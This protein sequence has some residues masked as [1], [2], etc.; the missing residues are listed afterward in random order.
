MI[1][2]RFA[3]SQQLI[4]Q[5]AHAALAARI[6]RQWVHGTL[7]DSPRKASILNAVE[8]H[9]SGWSEIDETLVVDGTSGHLVDFID[10]SDELKRETSS[11]GIDSLSSDPYAAALV[12]Q[13][14]LHVYRRYRDHPDWT[15]FF[16][17]MAEARDSCLSRADGALDQL[18]R[19]YWFVRA[20]NITSLAFCNNWKDTADDGCGYAMRLEETTLV[21]GPDPFAGRTDR[22]RHRCS[23]DR[24]STVCL[25]GGGAAG[26]RERAVR[27][28]EGARQGT[29]RARRRNRIV[30]VLSEG[31][32]PSD[33]PTRA[34]ARRCAGALRSRGSLA[35]LART[36]ERAPSL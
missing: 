2:R 35:R 19:D 34:L 15:A 8:Q 7:P 12:A 33:S 4:T 25:G 28:T 21:I 31:L 9:D 22:G 13:H 17:A 36:W 29:R 23:R 30:L 3:T 27:A 26:G 18:L 5:P 11:R 20:G 32:R 16:A 6:M 1:I 10:V 14:R 24:Q